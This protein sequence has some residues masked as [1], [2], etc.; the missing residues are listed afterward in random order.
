MIKTHKHITNTQHALI[1]TA[2]YAISFIF[3]YANNLKELFVILRH[4][5]NWPW[6]VL[7]FYSLAFLFSFFLDETVSR[8]ILTCVN[9][10]AVL[11]TT[12]VIGK[13]LI[14][15]STFSLIAL[16]AEIAIIPL[17]CLIIFALQDKGKKRSESADDFLTE[18]SLGEIFS[19][20]GKAFGRLFKAFFILFAMNIPVGVVILITG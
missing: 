15:N 2:F 20:M 6:T 12:V 16:I 9:P 19:D 7:G 8:T 5:P 18:E 11:L 17:L 14:T 10:Y 1:T 4:D 3:F 13:L